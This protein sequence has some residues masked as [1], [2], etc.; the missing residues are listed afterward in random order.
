MAQGASGLGSHILSGSDHE[1]YFCSALW[2]W[3]AAG[4]RVCEWTHRARPAGVRRAWRRPKNG[5]PPA[6]MDDADARPLGAPA[7]AVLRRSVD[8]SICILTH[9]QPEL[10][11][12]CVSSC[13]AE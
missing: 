10:L 8:L 4:V 12:R 7:A 6:P 13:M 11:P 3:L 2:C 1:T 9:C 5:E